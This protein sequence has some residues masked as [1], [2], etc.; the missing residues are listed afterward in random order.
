MAYPNGVALRADRIHLMAASTSQCKSLRH[1]IKEVN[2]GTSTPFGKLPSYPHNMRPDRKG[3]YWMALH[4]EK[5][6]LPFDQ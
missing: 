5:N 4:H 3:G 2:I 1:W 6:E